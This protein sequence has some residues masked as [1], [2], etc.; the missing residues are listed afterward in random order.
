MYAAIIALRRINIALDATPALGNGLWVEIYAD[1][2]GV[3]KYIQNEWMPK[4][5]GKN[6]EFQRIAALMVDEAQKL[7]ERLVVLTAF[8]V[9]GHTTNKDLASRMN[10]MADTLA[11]KAAGA[12][13]PLFVDNVGPIL[14]SFLE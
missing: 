6:A 7:R 1:Y 2:N 14:K 11:K 10:A 12:T 5:N 9:P 3:H 4:R 8:H 13:E